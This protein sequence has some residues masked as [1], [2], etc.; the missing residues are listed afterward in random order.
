MTEHDAVGETPVAY[1]IPGAM[2]VLP[3]G[4]TTFFRLIKDGEIPTITI[5]TRRLIPRDG[6][7]A[8]VER[9]QREASE[10]SRGDAA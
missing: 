2:E 5:G 9:L 1:S 3:V 10:A 8:Y 4:R 7:V 6:L